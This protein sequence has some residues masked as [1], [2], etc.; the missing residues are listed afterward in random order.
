[1]CDQL[2]QALRVCRGGEFGAALGSTPF[3][4]PLASDPLVPLGAFGYVA[5]PATGLLA[6]PTRLYDPAL[7]RFLSPDP[8][9]GAPDRPHTLNRYAYAASNPTRYFDPTGG[10]VVLAAIGAIAA[11]AAFA[12]AEAAN[13]AISGQPLDPATIG[14]A[15]GKGAVCGALAGA[16]NGLSLAPLLL[17]NFGVGAGA[18]ALGTVVDDGIHGRSTDYGALGLNALKDGALNAVTMTVGGLAWQS[19]TKVA[20]AEAGKDLLG[21]NVAFA[22]QQFHENLV[23]GVVTDPRALAK[24]YES[25]SEALAG[26]MGGGCAP[27]GEG[28]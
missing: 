27:E 12:A 15:A 24:M 17:A 2:G 21:R 28:E 7:G 3:G 13:E 16:T 18:S 20:G 1:M 9:G 5:D 14:V 22:A 25:V 19:A 8:V 11:G 23:K 10:E 26:F 4:A 6:S